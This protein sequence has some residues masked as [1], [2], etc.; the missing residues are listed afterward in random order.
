MGEDSLEADVCDEIADRLGEALAGTLP[1]PLRE[2][3]ENCD[4]CCVLMRAAKRVAAD[5]ED[6]PA[7]A[8]P[9]TDR[10]P[11]TD[12]DPDPESEPASTPVPAPDRKPEPKVVTAR[13]RRSQ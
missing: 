12:P 6:D 10:G 7:Q 3:A 13:A 2:H 1:A 8:E 11:D 5:R 4:A 9:D